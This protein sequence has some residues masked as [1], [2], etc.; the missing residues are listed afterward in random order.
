M[1][2]FLYKM[3]LDK[4]ESE[5]FIRLLSEGELTVLEISRYTGINRT[6]VYRIL[7][8]LEN[9]GFVVRSP[10]SKT[11]RY[12][13]SSLE[14]IKAKVEEKS[15]EADRL[16]QMYKELLPDLKNIV[17][18]KSNQIRVI[19]YTG[20]EEVKQLIWNSLKSKETIR[21]LGYR[22]IKEAVGLKFLIKWWD[23]SK[24]RGQTH[25]MIANSGTYTMKDT[26]AEG[27]DKK[28]LPKSK[29]FWK[30][31]YF[32]KNELLILHETF[33]YDDVFAILQWDKRQVFGVEVHNQAVADQQKWTFDFLWGQAKEWD[34]R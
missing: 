4:E 8:V 5:I 16:S 2:N 1:K 23:E 22:S 20:S 17:N 25:R 31:R 18:Q 26:A 19:H 34:S 32:E 12:G 6:N 24:L 11:T 3:G 13:A 33:V 28:F 10:K 7:E 30:R 29:G 15:R 21:S 9:R 27:S 14:F